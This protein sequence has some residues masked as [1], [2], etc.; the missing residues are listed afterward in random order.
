MSGTPSGDH[1]VLIVGSGAGGGMA[2]WVLAKAGVKVLMLE[3]G[4][5]Y[6]P[7][8]ETPMFGWNK[9]APLRGTRTPDKNFGFYDKY[10][11]FVAWKIPASDGRYRGLTADVPMMVVT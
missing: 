3:A 6:D 2:A 10:K 11:N 1:D 4:R 5:D 8:T 9:D 7:V